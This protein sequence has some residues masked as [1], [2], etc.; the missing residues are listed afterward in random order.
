MSVPFRKTV[1]LADAMATAGPV[2]TRPV[3]FGAH[4]LGAHV[5][6]AAHD[7]IIVP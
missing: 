6:G 2:H 4:K 3:P 1:F 5:I 7:R